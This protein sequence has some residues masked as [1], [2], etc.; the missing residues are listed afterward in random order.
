[1]SKLLRSSLAD[2]LYLR[3]VEIGSAVPEEL[4]A[5]HTDTRTLSSGQLFLALVGERF[6]AHSFV[7]DALKLGA[8]AVIAERNRLPAGISTASLVLVDDTL[9]A[10][11][12]IARAHLATMPAKRLALTGSNGKTTTKELAAA[13]L[14]ECY[15]HQAVWATRGNLNNHI[16][17]PLT[18]LEVNESHDFVIFEMGMNHLE[19]IATLTRIVQP[20]AGLITQIGTAHAGNVGGIEGVARAKGEL[21]AE[22]PKHGIAITNIDDHR[23]VAQAERHSCS[24]QIT[25]G[26]A[27]NADVRIVN[28]RSQPHGGTALTLS[29]RGQRVETTIPLDGLHNVR[30]AAGAVALCMALGVDFESAV[31][32]LARAEGIGG[33]LQRKASKNGALILDDTYNANPDS[34]QA[35]LRVLAEIAGPRRRVAALGEMREVE[36]AEASHRAIGRYAVEQGVALLF[37]C[38]EVAK[39]YVDGALEAGLPS[40]SC[41]WACDSRELADIVS[42]SIDADDVVLVKGS[43]GARMEI[44]V[45]GMMKQVETGGR[46][47]S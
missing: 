41:V 20:Q 10:L 44:V 19:E 34:M 42:A 25:F 36:A 26:L 13:A 45:D 31:R 38:G 28:S 27:D 33:R 1:M 12:D 9:L 43:R 16:G 2:A 39:F 29:W 47:V 35:G 21:F 30:N 6:D 40:S 46:G 11:Q 32:G 18:A 24:Q 22:L 15:G 5:L 37:A 17:V 7:E 23:C 8:S 4:G 3:D 14:R